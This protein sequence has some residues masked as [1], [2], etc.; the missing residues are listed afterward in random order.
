MTPTLRRPVPGDLAALRRLLLHPQ[1][2]AWLHPPA[3]PPMNAL[4]VDLVLASDR[5]HWRVHDYGPWIVEDQRGF[6][7]RVGLKRS[8]V[9]HG[10]EITWALLPEAWG[11]GLATHAARA[12][13]E[14][15]RERELGEVVAFTLPENTASVR[16][17]ERVGMQRA[18][19]IQHAGARHVLYRMPA[20]TS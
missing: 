16:V 18:G 15:A 2:R 17:M 9:L 20:G 19:D 1:V 14:L 12:A 7:G 6:C 13:V 5:E 10:V 4:E 3:A 8:E 11:R